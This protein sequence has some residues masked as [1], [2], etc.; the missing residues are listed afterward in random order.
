MTKTIRGQILAIRAS[1]VTNMF[2]VPRVR[3]EAQ[4]GGFNE[5]VQYLEEHTPAY[6]RFILTGEAEESK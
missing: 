6:S 1:G 2:D 4:N 3:W 5:L